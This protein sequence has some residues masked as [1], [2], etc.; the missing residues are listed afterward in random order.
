MAIQGSLDTF[1]LS[2]LLQMIKYER[3]SGRLTISSE[4]NQVQILMQEGDIVFATESR[5]SNRIGQLLVNNGLISAQT[6]EAA[7]TASREKNQGIGKTLVEQGKITVA[8]LNGFLLKQAENSLYNVFLWQT[9]Q[10]VYKDESIDLKRIVGSAFNTMNILLEASRRIDELAALKKQIPDDQ[11]VLKP[12]DHEQTSQN[13]EFNTDESMLLSMINGQSTVRQVIDETGWDDFTG[14]RVIHSLVSAGAIEILQSLP[15]NESAA[16]AVEQLRG[17]DARQFRQTL[18]SL[19][20]PRSSIL[21]LALTRLFRDAADPD[22]LMESVGNEA[23]KMND[24]SE[25]AQLERLLEQS[26]TSFMK[27]LLNLLW[28]EAC[29]N[30]RPY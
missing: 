17:V 24:P 11:S 7:L 21:R 2:N 8:E 13:L 30:C 6:L 19:A 15:M 28:Q 1:D 3:K 16:R 9:G 22:I 27:T 23:R 25:K 14:Y 4:S 10:F 29:N 12:C 18:D 26:R 20:L 5:K